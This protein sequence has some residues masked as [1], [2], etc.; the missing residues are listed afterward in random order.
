MGTI[1]VWGSGPEA[2]ALV[3]AAVKA[4]MSALLIEEDRERLERAA[5]KVRIAVDDWVKKGFLPAVE[6]EKVMGRIQVSFDTKALVRAE[7]VVEATGDLL[8]RRIEIMKE[9]DNLPSVDVLATTGA[10]GSITKIASGLEGDTRVVGLNLLLDGSR[11]T[12]CEIVRGVKTAEETLTKM[13]AFIGKIGLP[14]VV[15]HDFAGFLIN[16]ITVSMINEAAYA[17]YEGIGSADD[18]DKGF[19]E[20]TGSAL[21]PLAWADRLGIDRVVAI[22][23]EMSRSLSQ[24]RYLPCP[25]LVKYLEAGYLGVETGK[26]F[27]DYRNE[28]RTDE[29]KASANAA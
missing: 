23:Q 25:L 7:V 17:L 29:P 28:V 10:T 19:R 11:I 13:V 9:L 16:R 24:P 20:V 22:L 14:S 3:L 18:I 27:F 4:G 2:R 15:A 21:G 1:G 26:G 8:K 5:Q 12:L 6:K